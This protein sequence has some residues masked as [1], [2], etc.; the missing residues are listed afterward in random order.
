MH[1][2]HSNIIRFCNRPYN[3]VDEMND[4]LIKRWNNKVLTTDTVYF[5]G[6]FAMGKYNKTQLI[7]IFD[8][9]NGIKHLIFGNHD[10]SDV[11]SLPWVTQRDMHNIKDGGTTVAMCH[12]PMR[13]WYNKFHGSY[14]LFGHTHNTIPNL[15]RA[16]DVGVDAWE[17]MTPVT[18]EEIK[19]KLDKQFPGEN[20]F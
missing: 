8:S 16:C 4:D 12:Y 5:L 9:L 19:E 11:K 13:D 2:F 1:F 7:E 20:G 17:D 15:P 14:H 10:H 6:D 18:L 3:S